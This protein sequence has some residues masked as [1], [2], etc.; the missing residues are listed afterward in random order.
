MIP[1]P[2]FFIS[3]ADISYFSTLASIAAT[4][5]GLSFLSLSFFLTGLLK[6]YEVLALPI[7]R[8][9]DDPTKKLRYVFRSS[10]EV[11]DRNLLDSDPLVIFIAF[12]S[13]LSW[14]MY[15]L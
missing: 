5:L 7:Y 4:L 10:E 13:S 8:F 3:A 2:T 1:M 12:S 14:A 6:R 11:T 9:E 15:F